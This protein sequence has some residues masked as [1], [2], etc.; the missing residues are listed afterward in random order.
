MFSYL[1]DL[2]INYN[3]L[4]IERDFRKTTLGYDKHFEREFMNGV[5][6]MIK[7]PIPKLDAIRWGSIP[8]I[9]YFET[10]LCVWD[11]DLCEI[12]GVLDSR[13]TPLV[14]RTVDSPT[15]FF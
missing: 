2:C 15:C 10:A 5:I 9:G 1:Q 4:T 12:M 8:K 11:S 7:C 3:L 14:R 6:G 13:F